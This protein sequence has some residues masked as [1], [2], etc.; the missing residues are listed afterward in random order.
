MKHIG[1]KSRPYNLRR[2]RT[3]L[4]SKNIPTPNIIFLFN[5]VVVSKE[6]LA[7]SKHEWDRRVYHE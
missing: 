1:L 2:D 6:G 4:P 7:T 5:Y 3:K